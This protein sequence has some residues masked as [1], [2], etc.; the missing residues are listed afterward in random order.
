MMRIIEKK[1]KKQK[2]RKTQKRFKANSSF[3]PQKNKILRNYSKEFLYIY[4]KK[5][6]NTH[7]NILQHDWMSDFLKMHKNILEFTFFFFFFF[8]FAVFENIF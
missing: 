7:T 3:I 8:F 5:K 1:T 2:Q 4:K 6:R